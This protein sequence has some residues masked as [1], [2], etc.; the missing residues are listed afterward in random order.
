MIET[1]SRI[2]IMF[3][4]SVFYERPRAA[5]SWL[6]KA[7]GFEVNLLV[8]S[9]DGDERFIHSQLSLGGE[10]RLMVGGNW[11]DWARSPRSLSGAN[12]QCVRVQLASGIDE[13]CERARAAGAHI[14]Q[15]PETQF[16]GD[17]TYRCVDL[18]G[19]HWT[20]AQTVQRLSV[21]E[22]EQAGGVKIQGS[23]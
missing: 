4:S 20:F 9:P 14:V 19:H 13:H 15:E 16:Y 23:P 17:R 10:G 8:E 6:A 3:T 2:E 1:F 21:E 18:E 11:A 7:F 12:T 22:M 5:L